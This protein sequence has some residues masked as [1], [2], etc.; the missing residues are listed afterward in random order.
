MRPR[1]QHC[2]RGITYTGDDAG[3]LEAKD[4]QGPSPATSDTDER[5]EG[6][7]GS[8]ARG[9]FPKAPPLGL[10]G[11]RCNLRGVTWGQHGCEKGS[12]PPGGGPPQRRKVGGSTHRGRTPPHWPHSP[13][14]QPPAGVGFSLGFKPR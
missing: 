9:Q 7:T 5:H 4:Y 10:P 6:L 8:N 14:A 2:K 1:H 3:T 12:R 13:P 11:T